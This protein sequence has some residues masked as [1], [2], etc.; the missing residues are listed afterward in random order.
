MDGLL[1]RKMF[2]DVTWKACFVGNVVV[3]ICFVRSGL[4]RSGASPDQQ[5]GESLEHFPEFLLPIPL[6]TFSEIKLFQT[7]N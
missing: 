3:M 4:G 1:T 2:K 6:C 5:L 7:L